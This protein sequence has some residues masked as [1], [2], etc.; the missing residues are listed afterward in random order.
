MNKSSQT[1]SIDSF[2][3]DLSWTDTAELVGLTFEL[4]SNDS[5]LL[6]PDYTKGLHAWFLD[7]VRQKNPSLSKELHDEQSE[8]AFTIS[9]LEGKFSH[10]GRQLQ[11][12]PNQIYRWSVTALSADVVQWMKDWL[13]ALP[14]TLELRNTTLKFQSVNFCL[15]P[16]TYQQLFSSTPSKKVTLSFL[17]PTSFRHKGHHFPLPVP[18]NLFH[19]YLRRWNDF[20]GYPFEPETFLEWI[21]EFVLITRLRLESLKVPGGKKGAVTGFIGAIELSLTPA[22]PNSP[23]LVQLYSALGQ[24]APY[25]GTGHKTTFGLG[26]TRLGWLISEENQ[27]ISVLETVSLEHQLAQRIEQLTEIFMQ[28]QKR[29][30]GARALKVCQTRATILARREFGESLSAIATDLEMPYETVKTYAKL[31][32]RLF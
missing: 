27:P 25:C 30:G 8:K 17:S 23:E 29:T 3:T 24:F 32:R 9:R 5:A 7:Q 19:S 13:T 22:L 11:L 12:N 20:S 10:V 2:T 31:A 1:R 28:Q 21:D 14:E 18:T 15:P 4:V 6:S 26:Q 16:T